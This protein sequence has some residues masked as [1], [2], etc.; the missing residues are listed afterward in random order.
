MV[1]HVLELFVRDS[2]FLALAHEDVGAFARLEVA[3]RLVGRVAVDLA[4]VALADGVLGAVDHV[5]GLE[6]ERRLDLVRLA[7]FRD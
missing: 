2:R 3:P 5:L 6:L 1:Q 4:L 7:L